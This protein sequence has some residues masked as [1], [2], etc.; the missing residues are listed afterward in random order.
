M[1][2]RLA[3]SCAQGLCV[4]SRSN[5][6]PPSNGYTAK[7][8]ASITAILVL[9][10]SASAAFAQDPVLGYHF[11]TN[12]DGQMTDETI[13]VPANVNTN[14]FGL[15][16]SD[17]VDGLVVAQPLYV[18]NVQLPNGTTHN[19]VYI[20]TQHDSVFAFDADTA[21]PP[22]WQV[23]FINSSIGLTTV[24]IAD[25]LCAGSGF[26]EVG[27]MGTPVIDP[28]TGTIYL[29]AKT[30]EMP[31]SQ[32]NPSSTPIYIHTLHALDITT[33]AEKLGGPM[34]VT[35]SEVNALGNTVTFQQNNLGQCQRPGLV[36]SNGVLFVA[37]GSNGCDLNSH[38]WLMAYNAA[39]LQ[40]QLATFDTSPVPNPN[41]ATGSNLWMSGSG[42]ALDSNG[43]L[44]VS[45]ANGPYVTGTTLPTLPS[46][47]GAYDWGDTVLKLGFNGNS[48]I[49]D[50]V[51]YFTPF[52]Q[53]YMAVNDLDL[54]SGGVTLLP[55][56]GGL[57][58]NLLV[59]S[60]KTGN[61]YL[62]NTDTGSMGE[63]NP[64]S[65]NNIVQFIPGALGVFYSVPVFWYTGP[66]QG[67]GLV[68]FAARQDA[69]KAFSLNNGELSTT[70]VAESLKYWP[71]GIPVISSSGTTGGIL[72]NIRGTTTPILSAL[73]A[74]TLA[75][76]YNSSQN[77][78]RDNLGQV[79]HFVTPAIANNKV[80][81]GTQTTLSVYGVF[82]YVS[83][84]G[85]AGQSGTVATALPQPLTV[86]AMNS[87]GVGVSGITV[88]FSANVSG[89]TLSNPTAV[90]NSSG[91]ASTTYTLPSKAG[92][93]T[94][95]AAATGYQTL[96]MVETA[97]AGSAASIT[98]IGGVGQ[99]GTVG[100]T[101]P[102]PIVVE[103][104]DAYGNA[105]PG[106]QVNFTDNGAGGTVSASS[107]TTSAAGTASVTYTLPTTAKQEIITATSGSL[108][109]SIAEHSVAGPATTTGIF[110]GNKQTAPVNTQLK[111]LVVKVTDQYGNTVSGVNVTYSDG[112]AGGT[113]SSTTA[114]TNA[115]GQA[116]VTYTTP[117]Q[118]Q[119]VSISA[120]VP[121]I[122]P[123]VFTE[124]VN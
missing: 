79:A 20:V 36:L 26:T 24:P 102:N 39:N 68:Y 67:Q 50:V 81:M 75:E 91:I 32:I 113:F 45:T 80:F 60:G 83:T 19:V 122:S 117:V 25:Q 34:V 35:A 44:Y 13:L 123:A 58:P 3:S 88:T 110:S 37:Y 108:S 112:G 54:G 12:R 85:G 104:K 111:L 124:T 72:W 4:A 33:G 74:N 59:T 55:P 90:T 43:Y 1:D 114:T 95:S 100:T 15:L 92:S 22:L 46:P 29:S 105:I 121:G 63:Y 57:Y 77:S 42:I 21:G 65:T 89:G 23:S 64:P 66:N 96:A 8:A 61:I 62:I 107:V 86:Q 41:F 97:T 40:Q 53:N 118:P 73:D 38:G 52:D 119:V 109:A 49:I 101:L 84:Q 47:S 103:L 99:T 56:Q 17:A 31:N 82:P 28:T 10:L 87:Q 93:I 51:D 98:K 30:K 6:H 5:S 9:F 69:I 16:F 11:D 120:T 18:P 76:I 48:N 2:S 70:P 14:Q 115:V 94:I 78:S 7:K 27:I 116:S 71:I 106:Q